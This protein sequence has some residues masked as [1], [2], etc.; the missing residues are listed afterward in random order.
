MASPA[1]NPRHSSSP[2]TLPCPGGAAAG[3]EAV[4]PL[5]GGLPG[6]VRSGG[7][8]RSSLATVY[9][10]A[11]P[12]GRTRARA[13][14]HSLLGL[15]ASARRRATSATEPPSSFLFDLF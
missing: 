2:R 7:S 14:F 1:R 4:P 15:R 8:A 10:L 6:R 11:A 3:H 13:I 9:P 12:P 5:R